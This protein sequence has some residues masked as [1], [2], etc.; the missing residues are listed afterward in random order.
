LGLNLEKIKNN[1]SKLKLTKTSTKKVSSIR[2]ALTFS[3]NALVRKMSSVKIKKDSL[4]KK[5]RHGLRL[6]MSDRIQRITRCCQKQTQ[7]ESTTT[8][9]K[10][11][12][13]QSLNNFNVTFSSQQPDSNNNNT[14]NS[15][16][17]KPNSRYNFSPVFSSFLRPFVIS[18]LRGKIRINR[19]GGSHTIL[20]RRLQEYNRQEC[21]HAAVCEVDCE[22]NWRICLGK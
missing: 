20:Q 3:S 2:F 16:I 4:S 11:P 9:N 5:L 14:S 8:T 6:A 17:D 22:L 18:I 1:F 15:L 21:A 7:L 12:I 10:P 13:K 19:Q